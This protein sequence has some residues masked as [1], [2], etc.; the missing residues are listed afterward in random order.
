[1]SAQAGR[2]RW[3]CRRG[4]K[5]LDVLLTAYLERG[6]AHASASQRQTFERLLDLPDPDLL[7]LLLGTKVTDDPA[8]V[9]LVNS[10]RDAAHD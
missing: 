7:Q 9:D 10:I 5:E 3:R 4:A 2:V 1:M 8:V 6:Y